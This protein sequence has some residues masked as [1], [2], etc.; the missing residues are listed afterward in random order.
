MSLTEW[1][2]FWFQSTMPSSMVIMTGHDDRSDGTEMMMHLI[3]F[4]MMS[5]TVPVLDW[6]V[7]SV[8]ETCYELWIVIVLSTRLSLTV[9]TWSTRLIILSTRLIILEMLGFFTSS[10]HSGDACLV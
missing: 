10:D 7:S 3:Y 4:S 9:N 6:Y 5:L 1:T 2:K 8:Q